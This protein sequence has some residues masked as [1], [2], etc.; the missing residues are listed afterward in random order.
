MAAKEALATDWLDLSSTSLALGRFLERPTL[1]AIRALLLLATHYVALSPGDNGGAGIAYLVLTIQ[2]CISMKMQRDP[3]KMGAGS[4]FS[5]GEAEDRRRLFWLAFLASQTAATTYGRK[6][7]M[8]HLSDID[9]KLP[10]DIED[11][12]MGAGLAGDGGE[13]IMTSLIVRIKI[14]QLAEKIVSRHAA[15]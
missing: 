2:C 11:E 15:R 10:L 12:L 5:A 3:D 8:L 7:S 1:E 13:T 9:T 6:M 14:A 4:R